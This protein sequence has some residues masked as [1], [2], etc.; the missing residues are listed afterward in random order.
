MR[1]EG[2]WLWVGLK[3]RGLVEGMA[4]I[5]CRDFGDRDC[6]SVVEIQF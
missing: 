2:K 4:R 1:S 6:E 5:C 3:V